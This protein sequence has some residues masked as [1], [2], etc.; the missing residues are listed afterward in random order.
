MWALAPI[1]RSSLRTCDPTVTKVDKEY[2]KQWGNEKIGSDNNG[3][4]TTKYGEWLVREQFVRD[5]IPIWKPKKIKGLE[6]DWETPDYIIEVKTRNW[7]TSGTAG[8]KVFGVPYKYADV[9]DLYG[10][11]LLIILVAYQEWECTNIDKYKIFGNNISP[12]KQKQLDL[13]RELGIHFV[14]FSKLYK[15][16]DTNNR[17]EHTQVGGGQETIVE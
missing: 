3:N 13:W 7:T 16:P 15:D 6:P 1:T 8:E 11:P 17:N 2:E 4:W 14:P 12:N 10:K 9:P 5:N